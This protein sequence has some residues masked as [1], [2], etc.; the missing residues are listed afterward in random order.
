MMDI[1][2]SISKY[3]SK[4]PYFTIEGEM[5]LIFAC[6][7]TQHILFK[8]N[9]EYTGLYEWNETKYGSILLL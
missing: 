6:F 9:G 5:G 3:L 2:L 7:E 1:Y 8:I 4:Y